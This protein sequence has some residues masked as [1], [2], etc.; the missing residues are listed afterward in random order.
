MIKISFQTLSNILKKNLFNSSIRVWHIFI[1]LL[2][3][4]SIIVILGLIPLY[5]K[6]DKQSKDFNEL[7]MKKKEF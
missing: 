3:L 4:I 5:L 7:K 1:L 2:N 6:H